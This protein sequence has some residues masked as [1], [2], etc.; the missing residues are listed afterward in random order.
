MDRVDSFNLARIILLAGEFNAKSV[1]KL[2]LVCKTFR[3]IIL[4]KIPSFE[5]FKEMILE[6]S[7]LESDCLTWHYLIRAINLENQ[8]L[9]TNTDIDN[10]PLRWNQEP[11]F[12]KFQIIEGSGTYCLGLGDN[13]L[14]LFRVLPTIENYGIKQT[15][16]QRYPLKPRWNLSSESFDSLSRHASNFV[17]EIWRD[18]AINYIVIDCVSLKLF[19]I[20]IMD[21]AYSIKSNIPRDGFVFSNDSFT[22]YCTDIQG[23]KKAYIKTISFSDNENQYNITAFDT[24]LGP[25]S[26]INPQFYWKSQYMFWINNLNG[27]YSIGKYDYKSKKIIEFSELKNIKFSYLDVVDESKG[28]IITSCTISDYYFVDLEKETFVILKYPTVTTTFPG[29]TPNL[30]FK[31]QLKASMFK[32]KSNKKKGPRLLM[33]KRANGSGFTYFRDTYLQDLPL[34]IKHFCLITKEF[35]IW[36]K[37]QLENDVKV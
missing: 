36:D 35:I 37:K 28:Q 31:L 1:Y 6:S 22:T 21:D 26:L 15:L 5:C 14:V 19:E 17:F 7:N 27:I 11:L 10:G 20:K 18:G 34:T 3:E 32:V 2:G 33:I 8:Y 29:P 13:E 12:Q 9:T 16:L 30:H 24:I 23:L 25:E 4:T